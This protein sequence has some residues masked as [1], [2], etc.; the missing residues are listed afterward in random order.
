VTWLAGSGTGRFRAGAL[1]WDHGAVQSVRAA[2]PAK[3]QKTSAATLLFYVVLALGSGL[4]VL[5]AYK[6]SSRITAGADLRD[7]VANE[8]ELSRADKG[9]FHPAFALV[10]DALMPRAVAA[11]RWLVPGTQ[12]VEMV[13]PE[14]W[15]ID[16]SRVQCMLVE[17]YHSEYGRSGAND[18]IRALLRTG[19][20]LELPEL[21]EEHLSEQFAEHIEM[22]R[23][24]RGEPGLKFT[25]LCLT[26]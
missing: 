13:W 7:P 18:R 1:A 24:R 23:R 21:W 19:K 14:K 12:A 3:K 5:A 11:V 2:R 8:H 15:E 4:F 26:L 9:G 25:P 16:S 17:H 6:L 20:R 10:P 22:E